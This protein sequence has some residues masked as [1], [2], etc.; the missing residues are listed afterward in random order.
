[1]CGSVVDIQFA[2]AENKRGKRRKEEKEETTVL[3]HNGPGLPI[4]T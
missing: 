2:A 3:K 1:M 4:T